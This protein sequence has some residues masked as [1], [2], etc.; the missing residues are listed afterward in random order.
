MVTSS[1]RPAPPLL[2][3]GGA[4]G[5]LAAACHDA[6][7]GQGRLVIVEGR[8]G[9]GKSAL[10]AATRIPAASEGFEVLA[11]QASELEREY[12][13][14]VV[15]QL[16]EARL[17]R[18]PAWLEGAAAAA[19]PAFDPA[20]G[21]GTAGGFDAGSLV[22]LHVLD[23]LTVNAC[24]ETPVMLVVDDVHWCDQASLRFLAYVGRRLEGMSL[25]ILTGLRSSEPS[26]EDPL[27][28]EMA[29]QPGG[30][31]VEPAPLSEDAVAQLLEVRLGA[32][33][34]AGF[35]AACWRATGG[36]PLLLDE[37][38]PAPHADRARA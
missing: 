3:G 32:S 12:A 17:R 24:A 7:T 5:A 6:A 1:P 23:R 15:R 18:T 33:P 2:E 20:G 31:V 35:S 4:L 29:R 34:H 13:F 25:L 22:V 16:F 10:L 30:I 27:V 38:A 36:H 14:G 28:A 8:A 19:T 9:M 37:L 21:T 26:R 11:A